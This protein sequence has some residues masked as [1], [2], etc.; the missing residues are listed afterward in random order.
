MAGRKAE[1]VQA[2]PRHVGNGKGRPVR[3]PIQFESLT[4]LAIRGQNSPATME[5]TVPTKFLEAEPLD[6]ES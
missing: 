1:M 3:I 2:L 6:I 5:Q 4:G